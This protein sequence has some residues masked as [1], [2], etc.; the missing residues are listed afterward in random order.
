MNKPMLLFVAP[1]QSRSGYGEHSRDIVRSLIKMDKYDIK[2]LP[3]RWGATPLNCLKKGKDDDIINRILNSPQLPKKPELS[4]QLTVPNEFQQI[5]QFNVGITA[6]IETNLCSHNWIQGLNRMDFN[7]VPSNF[8]KT[9][10]ENTVY[11]EQDE[12]T[13]RHI[14]QLKCEK[15]IFVLFEGVDTSIFYKTD[16]I[17][18]KIR[19]KLNDI[20]EDF[21]FLFV[22]HWLQGELGA[23]RKDVGMLIKTFLSTFKNKKKKPALVIKTGNTFSHIDRTDVLEKVESIKRS[24]SGDLPNIYIIFGELTP[25]EMNGLYNHSKVKAHISFTKG[26]GFG[27]PLLEASLS[28]KPIIVSGWSGHTDFL[29]KELAVLLPGEIKEVHPSAVWDGVIERQ[30]KWFNVNYSFASNVMLDVFNRPNVY[31]P[32]ANLLAEANRQKFTF[33]KMTEEFDRILTENVPKF[34]VT[35]EIKLPKLPKLKKITSDLNNNTELKETTKE[36]VVTVE[37]KKNDEKIR[38]KE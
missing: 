35:N 17:P 32:N 29:P 1:V 12:A 5:A 16:N 38:E 30:S 10:F 28:G 8:S 21:V 34:V 37:E 4:I 27:R 3:I 2:I 15:P 7:I 22:G 19:K 6:G 26:E 23:D 24:I 14:S 9:V 11:T 25:E 33:D 36:S 13:K 31:L 18:T 20:P